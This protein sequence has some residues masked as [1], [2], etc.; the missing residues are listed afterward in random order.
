MDSLCLMQSLNRLRT[1]YSFLRSIKLV[2]G[3]LVKMGRQWFM[4]KG[5]QKNAFS[6]DES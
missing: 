2:N 3:W 1:S 4:C 6:C 5:I